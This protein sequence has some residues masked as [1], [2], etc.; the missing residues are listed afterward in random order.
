MV[1]RHPPP[2]SWV[3]TSG[4]AWA[5][6][7]AGLTGLALACVL[8]TLL[9]HGLDHLLLP[10]PR[11]VGGWALAGLV[12]LVVAG[13]R[14]RVL[15]RCPTCRLSW[16]AQRWQLTPLTL[17]GEAAG[18]SEAGEVQLAWD[19]GSWMGVRW[20]GAEGASRWLAFSEHP[21]ARTGQGAS[22]WHAWRVALVA[23]RFHPAQPEASGQAQTMAGQ[24]P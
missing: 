6:V 15:S 21:V 16:Q 1:M 20:R 13:W 9:A 8:G 5:W 12:G 23:Q 17:A 22:A 24:Q 18:P 19:L 3:S 14:H 2:A 11:G 7:Q 4:G 10:P